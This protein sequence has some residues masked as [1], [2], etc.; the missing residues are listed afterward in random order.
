LIER[1]SMLVMIAA[2]AQWRKSLICP[3]RSEPLYLPG[4]QK[5][6]AY[7]PPPTALAEPCPEMVAAPR[8]IATGVA[9]RGIIIERDLKKAFLLTRAIQKAPG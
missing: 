5:S 1:M 3:A 9:V 7:V 4:I 8:I 6:P 2:F